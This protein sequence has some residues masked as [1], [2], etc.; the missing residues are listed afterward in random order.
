MG[1]ELPDRDDYPDR[2][3]LIRDLA[4]PSSWPT[5][6]LARFFASE[7]HIRRIARARTT[8]PPGGPALTT[9]EA[10]A[11]LNDYHQDPYTSPAERDAARGW[12]EA[13]S[14]VGRKG[15]RHP[16]RGTPQ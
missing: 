12:I 1:E 7:R 16:S 11:M 14:T 3:S 5:K 10:R 2:D 9:D 4:G 15:R 6:K 8:T 13:N